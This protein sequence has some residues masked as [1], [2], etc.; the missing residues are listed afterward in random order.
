MALTSLQPIA[1]SISYEIKCIDN[2]H[3]NHEVIYHYYGGSSPPRS[4]VSIIIYCV[5]KEVL[6]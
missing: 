3:N 1:I 6:F 2:N 5:L 4:S